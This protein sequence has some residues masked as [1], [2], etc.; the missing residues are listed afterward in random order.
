MKLLIK[1]VVSVLI[2]AVAIYGLASVWSTI[3]L[4]VSVPWLWYA[5]RLA[6]DIVVSGLIV[7]P[8]FVVLGM[9]WCKGFRS[10]IGEGNKCVEFDLRKV[11][12]NPYPRDPKGKITAF[13]YKSDLHLLRFSMGLKGVSR[14]DQYIVAAPYT[15]SYQLNGSKRTI[16]V[17]KGMLTDLSSAPFPLNSIVGRVGPHLEATIVHDYLYVAWQ[18]QEHGLDTEANRKFA[19]KIMLEGMKASGMRCMAYLIYAVIYVFGC[20][21]YYGRDSI[22]YVYLSDCK[23]CNDKDCKCDDR[24]S[25]DDC[26]SRGATHPQ[27]DTE[28]QS[29]PVNSGRSVPNG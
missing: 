9:I 8:A 27:S 11:Q 26:C 28:A 2:G 24:N 10:K 14:K 1:F 29:V 6:Q 13:E 16:T 17:P 21:A 19:D 3:S 18:D 20:L 25:C 23:S 5:L 7:V 12:A 4:T 15:V 22:R